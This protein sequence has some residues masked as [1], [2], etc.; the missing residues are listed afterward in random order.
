MRILLTGFEPFGGNAIN[1]SE[2]VVL[3]LRGQRL[4]GIELHTAILPVDYERGPSALL[5]VVETVQP[6]VV[7]C[8]G[9]ARGRMRISIERVAINLLDFR[10][11]DNRGHQIV[12]APVVAGGPA[13]Y[14]ATLPVRAM[15]HALVAEDIPAELS[16]SAG[17]FLCNQVAYVLL[18]HIS[19]RRRPYRAGFIHLPVTPEQAAREPAPVASMSLETMRHGLQVVIGVL[20]APTLVEN[21]AAIA[22]TEGYGLPVAG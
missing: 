17:A 4:S 15:L 5:Q 16:L 7:L 10:L 13:A 14:F 2:Q 12:D 22:G 8:L 11:A 20:A 21:D 3:A 18:R 19:E 6:D 9:E 1:S